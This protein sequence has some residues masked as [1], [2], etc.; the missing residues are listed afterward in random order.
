MHQDCLDAYLEYQKRNSIVKDSKN[1][2]KDLE[3]EKIE[4]QLKN[5]ENNMV[6]ENN[7]QIPIKNEEE[8]T[9]GIIS[10]IFGIQKLYIFN[11]FRKESRNWSRK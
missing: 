3:E 9:I 4:N 11:L 5:E 7:E 2:K 6:N 1:E 10:I 8:N